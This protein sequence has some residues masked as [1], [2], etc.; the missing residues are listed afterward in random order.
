MVGAAGLIK[1]RRCWDKNMMSVTR[2]GPSIT[3][4]IRKN[5]WNCE[6]RQMYSVAQIFTVCVT[7]FSVAWKK[8]ACG[9]KICNGA[10]NYPQH[11]TALCFLHLWPTI[12]W[13]FG[14]IFLTDKKALCSIVPC[15]SAFAQAPI[16]HSQM[17][18]PICSTLVWPQCWTM[19]SQSETGSWNDSLLLCIQNALFFLK[20]NLLKMNIDYLPSFLIQKLS[21]R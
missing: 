15:P 2:T 18:S 20:K 1:N 11:K 21:A 19:N 14:G 16:C 12:S 4:V 9:S 17:S 5:S 10:I 7:T 6:N 8:H 3:T 13:C